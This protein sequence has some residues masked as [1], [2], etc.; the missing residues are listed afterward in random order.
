M[1]FVADVMLGRLARRLRLLGFDVLYDP[2]FGDNEVIRLG[3]EE[4]RV[5]LTRD[6]RLAARPLASRHVLVLG[7]RVQDQVRQVLAELAIPSP[8]RSF[9]RCSRC[10]YPL[11]RASRQDVRDLVPAHIYGAQRDFLRCS[12]CGRV[13]WTGSH[14]ARMRR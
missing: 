13:Y 7:D 12:G 9:T 5:I 4:Q 1:K 10:N 11:E 3:L 14:V 6:R 2:S 8:P